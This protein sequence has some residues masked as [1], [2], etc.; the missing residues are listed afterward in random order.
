[1]S[2]RKPSSSSRGSSQ[3]LVLIMIESSESAGAGYMQCLTDGGG[4]PAWQRL[5]DG[6]DG[7]A[8]LLGMRALCAVNLGVERAAHRAPPMN[9]PATPDAVAPGCLSPATPPEAVPGPQ[10]TPAEG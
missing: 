2:R 3:R 7:A 9:Q 1:M 10:D 4:C 5:H 6:P 8:P